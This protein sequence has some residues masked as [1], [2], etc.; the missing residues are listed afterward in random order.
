M[1]DNKTEKRWMVEV[2]AEVEGV[3]YRG[4]TIRTPTCACDGWAPTWAVPVFVGQRVSYHR[5]GY[6]SDAL[7][8]IDEQEDGK[9]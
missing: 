3:H 6:L 1:S 2:D 9:R 8:F 7:T 4:Y 5:F